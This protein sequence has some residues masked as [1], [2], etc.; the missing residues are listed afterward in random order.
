MSVGD[1]VFILHVTAMSTGD[2][3]FILHVTAMSVGDPV[4]ILHVTAMSVG[5]PV[6]ILHVTAMSMG[7]PIFILHVT[8]MSVGDPIFILHVTA[9]SVCDPVFILHVT[10]M[11]MGD[12]VFILHVTAMSMGDPVFIL[13]VTAMSMGD[14][15]FILHVTAMSMGDHVF[16]LHVTAMSAGAPGFISHVTAISMGAPVFILHVMAM[17]MIDPVFILHVT[18]MSMGAPIFIL[19][20]TAIFPVFDSIHPELMSTAMVFKEAMF[21]KLKGF[22]NTVSPNLKSKDHHDVFIEQ[23]MIEH[24]IGRKSNYKLGGQSHDQ[25]KMA[26]DLTFGSVPPFYREVYDIVCPNQ[27]HV[28]QDLFLEILVKS[29]LPKA[30]MLQIWEATDKL[31]KPTLG[32][33]SELRSASVRLRRQKTPNV[34]GFAFD[35]LVG[36]DTVKVE[37]LPEKKGLILKHVEY[38]VTSQ[39]YKATTLRRYNDFL[40]FHELLLMRFPYRCVPRLPPKKM[41]GANRE[42][43]EHRRKSLRRYLNLIARHPQ[44]HDDKLVQFFLSYSG[45]DVQHKIKETFRGIPDEFMTS[46]LASQ[47]KDLVPMDTQTQL[48]NSKDHIKMLYNSLSKLKDICE[49]M[50]LRSTNY[51]S[52]MLQFGKEL[53]T[54]V[55]SWATG[56]NESW[57]HLKKGF[58][59]LAATTAEEMVVEKL[60]LL[61]DLITSYR[62]LCERHEKGV[63][64]DHQRAVQKMGQYKKKKMSA[65]V[66]GGEVGAVDQLEQKILLQ[67]SQIANM[68]NRNYYSLHCLQME[69]QLIHANLDIL[70][71]VLA[72]M[73]TVESKSHSELGKVWEA[74]GPIIDNL[75]KE[76][77]SSSSSR[78]SASPVNNN[79]ISV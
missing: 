68:E 50:V 40:A 27:E 9:M 63:L 30:T 28:D 74:I 64:Q 15:V 60:S 52:D 75:Q 47:A 37:L 56:S 44:M 21:L 43:I 6:F 45:S 71:E 46:D 66:Q 41:M 54:P 59:H 53:S 35:E 19:H 18:A 55:S 33:L 72:A 67:E 24:R 22:W 48:G 77:T 12:P 76:G 11:S 36:L 16:I 4:F 79:K 65:T 3:V 58:K 17:S 26:A 73:A 20:V 14:P 70:Y 57:W 34:L 13:H 1:P 7:D 38:E 8:A 23:V 61:L 31:P 51:A 69:T 42:F 32:D 49:R 39:R 2:P 29:S 62:D 5:D 10:A 78:N 25:N